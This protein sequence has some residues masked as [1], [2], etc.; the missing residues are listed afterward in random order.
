MNATEHSPVAASAEA[1]GS[2]ALAHRT[3]T[4]IFRHL[5]L[6]AFGLG[7][8]LGTGAMLK[9]SHRQERRELELQGRARRTAEIAALW[10]RLPFVPFSTEAR[11]RLLAAC[12]RPEFGFSAQQTARLRDRLA[13]VLACLGGPAST[14][15][16]PQPVNG[17][18][19]TPA[20]GADPQR[21]TSDNV[22]P[23]ASSAGGGLD[24]KAQ[25]SLALAAQ[26]IAVCP[27]R[28]RAAITTTNMPGEVFN[29]PVAQGFTVACEISNPCRVH[30]ISAAR[31]K[32]GHARG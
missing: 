11:S 24:A 18:G 6:F 8:T 5:L 28:I 16:H 22:A 15:F 12:D 4:A 30:P 32:T 7:L 17:L 14:E 31:R 29:G 2:F 13:E 20:P 10:N 1:G 25:G 26:L 9:D 23:P 3:R 19:L 21:T 27:D